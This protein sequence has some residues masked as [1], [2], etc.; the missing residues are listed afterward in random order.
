MAVAFGGILGIYLFFVTLPYSIFVVLALIL[1]IS[2]R[3]RNRANT[4]ITILFRTHVDSHLRDVRRMT[5]RVLIFLAV[6]YTLLCMDQG[7]A[8][9]QL[10]YWLVA[11][12]GWLLVLHLGVLQ[13]HAAG[14][15]KS[16]LS[17]LLRGSREFLL[18][19]TTILLIYVIASKWLENLPTDTV[20][21]HKLENWD[22]KI[23]MLNA[24]FK[25]LK[26]SGLQ[27]VFLLSAFWLLMYFERRFR[28]D[29]TFST[30]GK[31]TLVFLVRWINRAA[32]AI[33]AA[34]SLTFLGTT[35]EGPGR[36]IAAQI[37]NAT[38]EYNDFQKSA[39]ERIDH[40][41]RH[42]LV[43][44]AWNNRPRNLFPLFRQSQRLVVARKELA[45]LEQE[46]S[47]EYNLVAPPSASSGDG[48]TTER[49]TAAVEGSSYL[50]PDGALTF[51]GIESLK[52][53]A[54]FSSHDTSIAESE[55][56]GT[57]DELEAETL[58]S[59][60]P[61]GHLADELNTLKS[62]A[63]QYPVF[64]EFVSTVGAVFVDAGFQ[65]LRALVTQR[66]IRLKT[67]NNNAS[68]QDKMAPEILNLVNEA[69]FDWSPY[70]GSWQA[71]RTAEIQKRQDFVSDRRE[72]LMHQAQLKEAEKINYLSGE[73][74][75]KR[76]LLARLSK[77]TH[78]AEFAREE[79][80]L[81]D[82]LPKL[83]VLSKSCP[84]LGPLKPSQYDAMQSL[85]RPF[86]LYDQRA[87]QADS[88]LAHASEAL[89]HMSGQGAPLF[90]LPVPSS[91]LTLDTRL[92]FSSH[93]WS[94]WRL[95]D[96]HSDSLILRQMAQA[97]T[98]SDQMEGFKLGL[99]TQFDSY[100]TALAKAEEAQRIAA[101]QE[102]KQR[103]QKIRDDWVE[104]H[105]DTHTDARP[106]FEHPEIP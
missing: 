103:V 76:E 99:G 89:K 36:F 29:S 105:P 64:G 102:E 100:T 37:K 55:Q 22:A 23:A 101:E 60:D 77:T 95:L 11:L 50:F 26:F 86:V 65:K 52:Q 49:K 48:S 85:L 31:K 57:E 4:V 74:S 47:K 75:K 41:I 8:I 67:A 84:A 94:A 17:L 42:A 71:K 9:N 72:R 68:L 83:R 1:A 19:V 46:A 59:L 81:R 45:Q 34:A 16:V 25:A 98:S 30:G 66:V 96:K 18:T 44:H 73:L 28:I 14:K 69:R 97:R 106:E 13:L 62:V 91:N 40:D 51:R 15:Q 32:L 21:L 24:F 54:Q 43:H 63:D 20:T 104:H 92:S 90:N 33:L 39:A 78:D 87:N 10:S 93:V 3:M 80:L 2:S 53:E 38:Q 58:D 56:K 35:S 61:A 6:A 12:G 82:V 79:R 5:L 7:V 88:L 27:L 70:S